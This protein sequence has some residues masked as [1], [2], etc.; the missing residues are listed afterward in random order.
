MIFE[1]ASCPYCRGIGLERNQADPLPEGHRERG[2]DAPINGG[3]GCGCTWT[4]CTQ[5]HVKAETPL[6]MADGTNSV[7][8]LYL[9][10]E[11]VTNQGWLIESRVTPDD[12]D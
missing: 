3:A 11:Q 4:A 9:D 12:A 10:P 8:V 6:V 1:S 2:H 5:P 7:I